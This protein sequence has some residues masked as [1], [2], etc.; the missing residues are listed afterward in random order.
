MKHYILSL[1]INQYEVEEGLLN[2][3]NNNIDFSYWN[4]IYTPLKMI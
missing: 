1:F 4:K 2:D 3:I